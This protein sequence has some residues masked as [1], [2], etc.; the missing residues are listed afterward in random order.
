MTAIISWITND[1]KPGAASLYLASD[2][3]ISTRLADGSYQINDD[4][5]QKLFTSKES[6]DIFAFCGP[7]SGIK[8]FIGALII[9]APKAREAIYYGE[10]AE[11]LFA[12]DLFRHVLGQNEFGLLQGLT[13][14]HGYRFGTRQFGLTSVVFTHNQK[15]SFKHHSPNADW[16]L[17]AVDGNGEKM[18]VKQQSEYI[19]TQSESKGY[20]R[21]L[22]MS[23]Y[24][25]LIEPTNPTC[26]GA[27]QIAALFGRNGGVELGVYFKDAAYVAGKPT[28]RDDIEYRDELFQRVNAQGILLPNAQPQARMGKPRVFEFAP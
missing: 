6:P 13:V 24:D 14:F 8:E 26:G 5:C 2:S 27:P 19:D 7:L 16:G 25:S 4:R 20:S 22:W 1:G 17:L 15:I 18:V 23:F 28:V 9:A 10:G 11:S 3:R 21:W 12:E